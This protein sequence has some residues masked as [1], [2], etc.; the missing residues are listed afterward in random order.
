[1]QLT[2]FNGSPRRRKSNSKLLIAKFLEGYSKIEKKQVQVL[3]IASKKERAK[4]IEAFK[5]SEIVIIFM[6]LYTDSMPGI[7]KEFFED[8]IN[9]EDK[10]T[11]KIGYVVQSGYLEAINSVYL[12]KYLKKFTSRLK[13]E[14]LGTVIKGGVE[15]IQ[16]M[17]SFM[18]NKLF[19]NFTNLGEQFAKNSKFDKATVKK[20]GSPYELSKN[21]VKFFNF[22]KFIGLTDFYWNRSLRKNKAFEKR[23]NHPYAQKWAR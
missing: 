18:T 21:M 11:K 4:R 17:P 10:K 7:V 12:A 5:N 22:L 19:K 3:Y 6:P 14:Y 2:I 9:I 1:M 20:L 16:T 15:G 23:F 8:I 13:I